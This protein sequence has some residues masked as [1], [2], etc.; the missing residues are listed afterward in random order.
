MKDLRQMVTESRE[1][2]IR[3][4][5][6]ASN[7]ATAGTHRNK[8]CQVPFTLIYVVL[9]LAVTV[10]G[11]GIKCISNGNVRTV[12]LTNCEK[13][14]AD[15]TRTYE[16][17][18][19]LGLE[20]GSVKIQ[21]LDIKLSQ[22][23]EKLRQN[24][25]QINNQLLLTYK[26]NCDQCNGDPCNEKFRDAMRVDS[27]EIALVM[28]E[29]RKLAVRLKDAIDIAADPKQSPDKR[30]KASGQASELLT[31]FKST[32]DKAE[33]LKPTPVVTPPPSQPGS[34][35]T[36]E[37]IDSIIQEQIKTSKLVLDLSEN[38]ARKTGLLT[39]RIDGLWPKVSI[40]HPVLRVKFDKAS[41]RLTNRAQDEIETALK[42]NVKPT[43]KLSVVGSADTSGSMKLNLSLS[44]DRAM[45]VTGWLILKC[46][47]LP[48]QVTTSWIGPCSAMR[49]PDD[50]RAAVI[51]MAD[52]VGP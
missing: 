15:I 44:R 43:T 52:L 2:L 5:Q 18:I 32:F 30:E 3:L 34:D 7:E 20:V 31:E 27:K 42:D 33:G 50:N 14:F 46:G 28:A 45:A 11:C 17:E 36:S 19:K 6:F 4:S 8:S 21:S 10:V 25:D 16:P 40:E 22:Q 24:Y 29:I 1:T 26:F 23:I 38:F 13:N 41:A 47:V 37:K 12:F 39:E 51:Y 9:I 49:K 35:K 48:S